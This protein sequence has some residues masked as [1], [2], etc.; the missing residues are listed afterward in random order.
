M[1]R[2]L[3]TAVGVMSALGLVGCQGGG[4]QLAQGQGSNETT[5]TTVARST[6]T[7]TLA[8]T[9]T[10]VT[11]VTA[12]SSTTTT[13]GA[14]SKPIRTDRLKGPKSASATALTLARVERGLRSPN[15]DPARLRSLGRSQQLAYRALVAHP[16]WLQKVLAGVPADLR[17]AVQAN[18][19]AGSALSSLTG[20]AP[21]GFPDWQILV[22]KPA[23]TLRAY[24]DEAQ[25]TYGISWA[26]LAAIHFVETRMGRIHGNS[27]AGAQGP[28]Q[29]IPTTWQA[30]GKGGDINDDHDAILAAANYLQAN[31]AA[32]DIDNAL[33]RY[34]NDQRYV[35]AIK[36]Y[37]SV[38]LA[39][40][41]AFD[42]YYQWQVFYATK[43]GAFLLPEGWS[44][45]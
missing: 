8:S 2:L 14:R 20:S 12:V 25:Q 4:G 7:T 30:F 37:A 1:R 33:Y 10:T 6:T 45:G 21:P 41:G 24:Y 42:G 22:P 9:A 3:P 11:P 38:M 35:T 36:A 15:R 26:Y 31:S 18:Y 44:A 17:P 5:T 28:M 40:Q 13:A 32:T 23:A 34:N 19:D 29:F 43:D 27:S 39:D 16:D